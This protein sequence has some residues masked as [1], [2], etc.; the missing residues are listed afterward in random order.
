LNEGCQAAHCNKNVI[1][2]LYAKVDS[3][4]REPAGGKQHFLFLICSRTELLA[5]KEYTT[6]GKRTNFGL[7]TAVGSYQRKGVRDSADASER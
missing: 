3:S 4:W 5:L 1:L 6:G 2:E 7:M